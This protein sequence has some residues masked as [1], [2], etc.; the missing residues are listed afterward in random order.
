[1][2]GLTPLTT[3]SFRVCATVGAT[4]GAWSQAVTALV[5]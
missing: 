2:S 1:V 5:H 3:V 4:V